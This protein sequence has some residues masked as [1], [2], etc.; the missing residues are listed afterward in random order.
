MVEL[1]P[2][3]RHIL[4]GPG[5][6]RVLDPESKQVYVLVRA[7][8]YERLRPFLEEQPAAPV[9]EIPPVFGAP[10]RRFAAICSSY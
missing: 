1:S 5:P 6:A 10:R 9:R 4:A 8:E 3:Q 2:E 7:E